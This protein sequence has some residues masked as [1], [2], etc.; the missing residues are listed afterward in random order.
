MHFEHLFNG[1]KLLG[2]TTNQFF[3]ENWVDILNELKKVLRDTIGSILKNVI[4]SVFSAFPYS[5]FFL[6]S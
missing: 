1:D 6:E 2:D 3:N 4:G 5:D